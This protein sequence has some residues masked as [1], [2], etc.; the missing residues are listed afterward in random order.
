MQKI[1]KIRKDNPDGKIILTG[2][3]TQIDPG[4]YAEHADYILGNMEKL[5]ENVY[6]NIRDG[7]FEA[8]LEKPSELRHE[9]KIFYQNTKQETMRI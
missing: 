8:N 2:C 1:K 7:K 5:D 6:N 9:D 3:A 4:K